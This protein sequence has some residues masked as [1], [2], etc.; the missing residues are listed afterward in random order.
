MPLYEYECQDCGKLFEKMVRLAELDRIPV[1]PECGS[2][3]TR[4]QISTFASTSGN[5]TGNHSLSAN[6]GC[7]S[8]GHFT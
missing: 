2:R 5:N 7:S 6:Q 1:C 8:S 3:H 4:K